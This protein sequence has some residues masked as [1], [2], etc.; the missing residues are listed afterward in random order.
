MADP[1]TIRIF[2]PDGD[3]EGVRII[4]KM[5]WTGTGISFP[6]IKWDEIKTRPA[7]QRA[8]I[9]ILTG[10]FNDDDLP[11][12]YVGRAEVISTR[13]DV[14]QKE[15]V[16]WDRAIVFTSN[17][18]GLNQAHAMWLEYSLLKRA[19]ETK[20]CRLENA[21]SPQ[22]PSL[23]EAENADTDFFLKQILQILPLVELRAFE[24]AKPVA[25]PHTSSSQPR[26]TEN[27]HEID[28]IIVSA[29]S[30]GF[31]R[32]FIRE[33]VWYAVRISGGMLKK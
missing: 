13:I 20:R 27:N 17:S 29:R 18:G 9:Y 10:Y 24:F 12:L 31:E 5:N 33:N 11:T 14:H 2:V 19:I 16:F 21:N 26:D 25:T 3:P 6:R 8:G 15:K 23:S 7:L 1:F 4:D 22:E 30:E 32:V 28:T